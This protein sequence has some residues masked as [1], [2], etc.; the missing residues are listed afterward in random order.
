MPA[1]R[2]GWRRC[3][4]FHNCRSCPAS[5]QFPPNL[6]AGDGAQMTARAPGISKKIEFDL[7]TDDAAQF[8]G[9]RR[10]PKHLQWQEQE[11]AMPQRAAGR[12]QVGED[13]ERK[14]KDRGKAHPA[15]RGDLERRVNHCAAQPNR[16]DEDRVRTCCKHTGPHAPAALQ[17]E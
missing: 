1:E 4:L 5:I 11:D 14:K 3:D 15:F 9:N 17:A 10:I 8:R 6:H 2:F 16:G 13:G 7:L 12:F